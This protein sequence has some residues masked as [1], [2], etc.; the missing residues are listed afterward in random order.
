MGSDGIQLNLMD[1]VNGLMR[2]DG[3]ESQPINSDVIECSRV[4]SAGVIRLNPSVSIEIQWRG[5]E[6]G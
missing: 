3:V 4:E 5:W 2:S 6:S 1:C